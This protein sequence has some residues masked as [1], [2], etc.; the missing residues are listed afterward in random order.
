M[1]EH[2]KFC[3][4]KRCPRHNVLVSAP[5][6]RY[7]STCDA[8][9]KNANL[10]KPREWDTPPLFDGLETPQGKRSGGVVAIN[11]LSAN[12]EW[13]KGAI[14]SSGG[15]YYQHGE[16]K[17]PIPWVYFDGTYKEH[18]KYMEHFNDT[19]TCDEAE[20]E[21]CPL[22]K[23]KKVAITLP[24]T[25][26]QNLIWLCKSFDT[27]WIAFLKGVQDT[28]GDWTI[29]D[30]YFPKQQATAFHVDAAPRE[31]QDGTIGAIHSHVSMKAVFSIEDIKH[32]NHPVEIVINRAG[33][34]DAAVRITLD[35]GR[36][37]RA[38]AAILLHGTDEAIALRDTLKAK[39]QLDGIP[40]LLAS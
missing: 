9:L 19:F 12:A 22:T 23:S 3:P 8:K 5:N 11:A 29:T 34:F 36:T 15:K 7:C 25:M 27:E 13:R 37:S 35:C 10:V 4:S 16:E 31:L 18:E 24:N 38:K 14:L 17:E 32:A 26:W 30:F 21:G 39:L 28:K 33:E 40:P 1:E 2:L 6:R 20:I